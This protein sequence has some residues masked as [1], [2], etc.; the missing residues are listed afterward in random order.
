MIIERL[1]GWMETA[2]V[3]MREKAVIALVRAFQAPTLSQEDRESAEAAMTCI[4]D[5]ED[6]KVRIALANALSETP[7]SPRHLILALANDEPSVS[8]P[9]LASSPVLLDGELIKIIVS[10][11]NE[12][13]MAIACRPVLS[14]SV[15][16]ALAKDGCESAC[17][18]LVTNPAAHLDHNDFFI[19]A[20]RHGSQSELRK[21]LLARPDIGMA[22]RVLLI[23]LYALTLVDIDNDETDQKIVEKRKAEVIEI[24]DKA[25]ITFA[26]QISDVEIRDVVYAL[27]ERKKLTTAFL[28]RSICMGNLSLF[29][30]SLSVLSGQTLA[31]V[32]RVLKD[33]R[34]NAMRAIYTKAGLPV[35]ALSVFH[36]AIR[37]WRN[38]LSG[39]C[40]ID[41]LKLPY[42]VTKEV[43]AGY[44]GKRDLVVDELLL[45]LRKICTEA[46][47]ECARNKVEQMSLSAN[48]IPQIAAPEEPVVPELSSEDLMEFAVQFADELADIALEDEEQLKE[49]AQNLQPANTTIKRPEFDE[50]LELPIVKKSSQFEFGQ[51]A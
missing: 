43:L 6:Q 29:A 21:C 39:D 15:C 51:A 45:L 10:G 19:L 28:L 31:R 20:E 47:R 40:D 33:D 27:I 36:S 4:L 17:L 46:A 38:H 24:C 2:P 9:V 13:Q 18:A 16:A 14:H 34:A 32:E 23:E 8:L 7:N 3:E 35:S 5:D 22:A 48:T 37:S 44:E 30:Q 25:T 49:A 11:S 50:S 42:L 1:I 41:H 26:A 12:Q